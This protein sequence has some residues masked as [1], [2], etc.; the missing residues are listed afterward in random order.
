MKCS[1]FL[2]GIFIFGAS[3]VSPAQQRQ[4]SSGQSEYDLKITIAKRF[5]GPIT[6]E[7][8]IQADS[9]EL[10]PGLSK[11]YKITAFAIVIFNK[12]DTLFSGLNAKNGRLTTEMDS[13]IKAAPDFSRIVFRNIKH[14]YNSKIKDITLPVTIQLLLINGVSKCPCDT[15][16]LG[17]LINMKELKIDRIKGLGFNGEGRSDFIKAISNA[18]DGRFTWEYGNETNQRNF[19]L[20]R[21]IASGPES[22]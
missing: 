1:F 16:R 9:L 17:K 18:K 22:Y 14:N 19:F 10:A 12:K 5:E 7:E 8:L 11:R 6:K 13:A 20:S 4:S 15:S 21:I 2:F 3:T